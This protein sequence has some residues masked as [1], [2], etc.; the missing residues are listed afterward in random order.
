[1]AKTEHPDRYIW[2][3]NELESLGV[4]TKHTERISDLARTSALTKNLKKVFL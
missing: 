2:W 4:H 3:L 1:M